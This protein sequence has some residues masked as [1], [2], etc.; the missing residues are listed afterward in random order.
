M[1]RARRAIEALAELA[2]DTAVV[3]RG[4]E[5]R[6]IPVEELKVGDVVIV[7]TNG[8]KTPPADPT[9]RVLSRLS[10]SGAGNTRVQTWGQRGDE[11]GEMREPVGI[12]VSGD[13]IF[14][15]GPGQFDAP[16]S[17]TVDAEGRIYVAYVLR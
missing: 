6:E 10:A 1:G 4:E 17:A 13:E 16:T 2:P 3:R 14:V 9:C 15:T 5:E 8:G 7:H 11:P 12:A